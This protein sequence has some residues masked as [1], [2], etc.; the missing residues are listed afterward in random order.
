M[1]LS[2]AS[3]IITIMLTKSKSSRVDTMYYTALEFIKY[4]AIENIQ[5]PIDFARQ[6]N[7]ARFFRVKLIQ[8]RLL[9][10]VST[11]N[12][13][14]IVDPRVDERPYSQFYVVSKDFRLNFTAE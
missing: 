6:H 3:P 11:L 5:V 14:E 12:K 10:D 7:R 9:D 4:I 13:K 8:V 1:L 2:T